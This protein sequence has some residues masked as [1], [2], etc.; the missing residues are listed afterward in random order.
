MGF[1]TSYPLQNVRGLCFCVIIIQG[2]RLID[3]LSSG[4]FAGCPE[5]S[6]E[7][8]R[9]MV[10]LEMPEVIFYFHLYL[11]SLGRPRGVHNSK[12]DRSAILPS[13][14]QEEN[15]NIGKTVRDF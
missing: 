6:K 13:A 15:Q 11:I 2:P 4:M 7:I 3:P 10:G 9:I 12:G 5:R 8:R 14:L 1:L